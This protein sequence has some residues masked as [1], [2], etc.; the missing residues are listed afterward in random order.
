MVLT[1]SIG[2][3]I[4]LF[5]VFMNGWLLTRHLEA[6]PASITLHSAEKITETIEEWW[7]VFYQ[8]EKIGHARQ[9]IK[10]T[11]QG[12]HIYDESNLR[13]QLLGTMQPVST[14]LE[15]DVDEEWLLRRFEYELRSNEIRFRSR[16]VATPGKLV[17]EI[18]SAGSTTKKQIPL[19]SPPYLMAALKPYIATQ[20]LEPGK[21]HFF[22]VF[23]P[24]T[25]SQQTTSVTIESR[26]HIRIGRE[27]RPAMRIRQQVK[28]IAV[29]S[30]IDG[31]GRTLREESPAG[32]ALIQQSAT[33][34]QNISGSRSVPLDLIAQTAITP[35]R[36]ISGPQERHLLTLELAGIDVANFPALAGG[37]QRLAGNRLYIT[38]DRVDRLQALSLPI[39]DERLRPFLES[40]PFIQSDH[41]RIRALAKEIVRGETD[42]RRAALRIQDWVY[43]EIAK[44]PTVSI[45]SALEVL[46]TKKGDCNEHTV[47]FNALARAVGLP[48]KTVVGMVYVRDAFYYHAWSEIWLGEWI[49]LDPVLKQFPADVTHVKFIEGEI[50]RQIDLLQLIG[51]L[52]IRVV[53]AS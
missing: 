24:A 30:W 7:G 6:P 4:V 39:R 2:V 51:T 21:K 53:E 38:R 35:D 23:D 52:N 33:D 37:R 48:A 9:I 16:G 27:L 43:R 36:L 12:Y 15:M 31:M 34:A 20:Q 49:S 40:T 19:S 18:E 8:R 29:V 10:P 32:L 17:L 42:A 1:R 5:W 46:E 25:L 44:E 45:P 41:P 26:E 3:G 13:L 28:G 47:L 22:S 14:R 50:D 11:P